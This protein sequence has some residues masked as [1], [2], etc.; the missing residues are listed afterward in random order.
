M[1]DFHTAWDED[2]KWRGFPYCWVTWL[3]AYLSGDESCEAKPWYKSHYKYVKKGDDNADSLSRWK[4][5]H[6]E[7]VKKL[8]HERR[9]LHEHV[10]VED[11]NAIKVKGRTVVLA[12]KP[13]VTD[14][15]ESES[16]IWDVKTGQEKAADLWQVRIYM[17][18]RKYQEKGLF[19][20]PLSKLRGWVVY[21]NREQEVTLTEDDEKRIWAGA[22]FLGGKTEPARTPSYGECRRCDID[23]CPERV[24]DEP[25]TSEAEAF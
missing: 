5:D 7:K 17:A 18:L 20:N 12:G 22:E 13:D 1:G 25:E 2:D 14:T 6:G 23:S 21:N 24:M 16:N 8:A 19:D 15:T 3:A 9:A 10:Y 11:Q 4:V